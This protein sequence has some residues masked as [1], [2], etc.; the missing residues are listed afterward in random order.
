MKM[1]HRCLITRGSTCT[2]MECLSH[3]S[4]EVPRILR[5]RT[6]PYTY[7]RLPVLIV[8][9]SL[10]TTMKSHHTKA[11]R[12]QLSSHRLVFRSLRTSV[13]KDSLILLFGFQPTQM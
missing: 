7:Q 8:G 10:R 12:R 6:L 1:V 13:Q 9:T 11:S 2:R 4:P 3:R 5:A